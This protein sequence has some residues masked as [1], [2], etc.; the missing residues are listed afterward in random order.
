MRENMK[1]GEKRGKIMKTRGAREEIMK[2]VGKGGKILIAVV[3][4]GKTRKTA[5]TITKPGTSA[6][7]EIKPCVASA[8]IENHVK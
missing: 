7:S 8:G 6:G 2:T 4:R 1:T 5:L 3:K